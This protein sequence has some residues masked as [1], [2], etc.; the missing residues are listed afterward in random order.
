MLELIESVKK[1]GVMV[2]AIARPKPD[3]GYELVASHRRQR[4]SQLAGLDSMP[5]IV[6]NLDDNDTMRCWEFI[7]V[8]WNQNSWGMSRT[9]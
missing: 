5:V 6:M 9:I 2:P 1:H 7:P 4:A 8:I 3:G